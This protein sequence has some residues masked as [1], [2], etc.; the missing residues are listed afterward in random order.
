MAAKRGLGRGLDSLIPTGT[1]ND[2]SPEKNSGSKKASQKKISSDEN[3]V[4]EVVKEVIK[5]VEQ[6]IKITEIEPNREQPRKS[7][8][9]DALNELADSIK[10]FGI[11]E[12]L[13]V[14]KKDNY[15]E[16]IAGER[17]WRAARIA[18]LKEVPV[19]IKNYNDRE[20]VEIALIENI[21][22]EDLNPIEE[23]MAYQRLIEEFNLKQDDVA[24]RVSKSRTT[25]TNSLRLLKL[26]DKVQQMLID[27]MLSTGHVR[28]LISIE[29]PELQYETAM[30]IF[31]KKLSVRE[32]ERYVK[33]L[34]SG[35]DSS[36]KNEVA[37]GKELSFLYKDIEENLKSILGSKTSIK[38]K[39]NDRGKIEIEYYSSDDL[40]RIIQLLYNAK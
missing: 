12:P 22:R 26:C 38:P 14:V 34:L 37:A 25:I 24:E 30:Y 19:V 17:R 10:Q 1:D 31:D 39:S 20:R 3:Q 2:S 15:Y 18:G 16:L 11:I 7:F 28:S 6:K 21:Q 23:A 36:S 9:E 33:K 4:K 5:E 27:E 32:T 40:E 29:D 13:V 8:N 35:E